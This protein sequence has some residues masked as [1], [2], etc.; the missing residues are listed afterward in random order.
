MTG[1]EEQSILLLQWQRFVLLFACLAL[2]CILF[3]LRGG[4]HSQQDQLNQLARSSLKPEV[5]LENGHPTIFEFYADWCEACREMAP[6]MLSIK[7]EFK[8]DLDL[9]LLNVDND[10]WQDLIDEYSVNGIP[11]LNFFDQNG[12]VTGSSI[13][14]K[15]YEELKAITNTILNQ[16]QFPSFIDEGKISSLENHLPL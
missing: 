4:I 9:V 5:A 12:A 2:T 10:R 15:R 14:L 1:S 8:D 6:E 16:E 11:Q 7:T 13:G 3:F